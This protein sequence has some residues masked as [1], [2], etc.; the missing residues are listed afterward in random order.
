MESI[1]VH[2]TYFPSIAQM[3]AI[4]QAEKVNFEVSGNYQK[5]SYRTR[6]YIAHSNGKLLLNV[7]IKHTGERQKSKDIVVENEF[8]WQSQHWKSLETAYR[9]SPFFEFYE[10]ELYPLFNK[11]VSSLLDHNL[12]IFDTI[13]ELIELE[14]SISYTEEYIKQPDNVKNLRYLAKAK[15]E[16][17]FQLAPYYQ[18][19][20]T[21]HGFLPN[22]SILDLLFNEGPNTLNYLQQQEINL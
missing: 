20:E 6:A 16:K 5:Q 21:K 11:K 15:K 14:P 19:F 22:L 18:V 3:V 10:D 9:T 8:P 12:Q 13:C 17:S 4:S 2:P 7:P 1:L